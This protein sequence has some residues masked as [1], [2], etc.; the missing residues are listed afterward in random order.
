L[1]RVY[2]NDG[3]IRFTVLGQFEEYTI[4]ETDSYSLF[5]NYEQSEIVEYT[6]GNKTFTI[7]RYSD[8]FISSVTIRFILDS[9]NNL[10]EESFLNGVYFLLT[11]ENSDHSILTVESPPLYDHCDY[12]PCIYDPS[13]YEFNNLQYDTDSKRIQGNFAFALENYQENENN[14]ISISGSFDVHVHKILD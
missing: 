7:E 6:N 12:P 1:Y 11:V 5:S 3:Y 8:D 9:L 2:L 4:Q 10:Q 13:L 14:F